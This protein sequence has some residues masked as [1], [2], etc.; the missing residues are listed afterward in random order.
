[1]RFEPPPIKRGF[2]FSRKGIYHMN[3]GEWVYIL[4]FRNTT[5]FLKKGPQYVKKNFWKIS[6]KHLYLCLYEKDY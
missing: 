2:L 3:V 4:P 1:M 5:P 6:M